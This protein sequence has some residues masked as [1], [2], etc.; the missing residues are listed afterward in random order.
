MPR[1]RKNWDRHLRD[2]RFSRVFAVSTRSQSHFFTASPSARPAQS[3]SGTATEG[4]SPI[5]APD[6]FIQWFGANH[7]RALYKIIDD[8]TLRGRGEIHDADTITKG[9]VTITKNGE[10]SFTV[11]WTEVTAND[12]KVKDIRVE[13][14]RK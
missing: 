12:E 2:H 3:R 5:Y 8:K 14:T 7:G 11:H 10:D 4:H 13:A 9:T 1:T 6:P